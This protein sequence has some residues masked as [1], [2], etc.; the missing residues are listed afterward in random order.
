M[1]ISI[2][3]QYPVHLTPEQRERLEGLTRN[4][5]ASAGKI[6]RAQVLLLSDHNRPEGPE[7][8]GA[9]AHFLGMHVNTVDRIRKWFVVKGE[10]P[11]LERKKRAEPPTRPILDGNGEAQLIAIC[12]G[13]PPE[14]RVRW[15]MRLLADELKARR[16]VTTI[17]AETVRRKLKKTT[18][19]L[20]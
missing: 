8:R 16:I 12:C 13:S 3:N 19:S 4:G 15:T 9:I 17:S 7:T 14:G 10:E 18:S 20:G 11:A 5:H 2:P 1:A 6:R